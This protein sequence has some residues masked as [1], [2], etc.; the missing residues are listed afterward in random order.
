MPCPAAMGIL[1]DC[2]R[3]KRIA[4][5][6]P[7]GVIQHWSGHRHGY[8]R[9]TRCMERSSRTKEVSS[10]LGGSAPRSIYFHCGDRNHYRLHCV[11][12]IASFLRQSLDTHPQSIALMKKNSLT[13]FAWLSIGTALITMGLKTGAWWLTGSVGLLSDALE[14][15]VNLLGG[16][17]ALNM[18]IVAERPEEDFSPRDSA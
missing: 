3:L 6:T 16:I 12:K 2:L 15:I 4:G 11:A 1:L 18:I 7:W 14:A 5:G 13:R 17:M 9:S 8:H 10:F